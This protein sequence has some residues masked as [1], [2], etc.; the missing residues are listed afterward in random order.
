M[1]IFGSSLARLDARAMAMPMIDRKTFLIP[2][3]LVALAGCAGTGT[4]K[5]PSLAIR[6]IERVQGTF[7]PVATEQLDVPRVEV[8]YSGSL[9]ERLSALVGQAEEAHRVFT[10]AVPE[11]EQRASAAND[12]EIG[13]EAWA[14]AQVALAGLDSARS[15]VAAALGDL[16]ILHAAGAVQAEDVSAIDAARGKVIALVNIEDATL[17]RLRDRVR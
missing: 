14:S 2:L 9:Q 15:E 13:S 4:G 1:R 16:D 5:Y 17:E 3:A 6:D 11:A 10:A 7:E 12:A 8:T